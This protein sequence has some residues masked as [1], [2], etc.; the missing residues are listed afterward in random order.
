MAEKADT[1]FLVSFYTFLLF[2]FKLLFTLRITH[3]ELRQE[4]VNSLLTSLLKTVLT[5]PSLQLPG[6]PII[7]ACSRGDRRYDFEWNANAL[8][9]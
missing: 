2:A 4:R 8:R 1:L 6:E 3:F 7:S 9:F 5:L